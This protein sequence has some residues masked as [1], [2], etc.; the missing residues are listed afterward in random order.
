[1]NFDKVATLFANNSAT[2]E[3]VNT[4][5]RVP[6]EIFCRTM[7]NDDFTR[8]MTSRPF[9][10]SKLVNYHKFNSAILLSNIYIFNFK[11]NFNF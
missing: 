6:K 10:I 3:F 1:M 7:C 9:I 4:R 11:F 5:K 2:N 8:S